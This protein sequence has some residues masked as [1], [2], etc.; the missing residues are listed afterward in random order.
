VGE[1]KKKE[2][3]RTITWLVLF[4]QVWVGLSVVGDFSCFIG[5]WLLVVGCRLLVVGCWLLV[6]GCC[7]FVV[8]CRDKHLTVTN[9]KKRRPTVK[10]KERIS[11][12]HTIS[13]RTKNHK[14][15]QQL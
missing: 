7:L 10:N 11:K 9:K 13:Q 2:K 6:D 15:L 4:C 14:P 1:K 3:K 8:G 5:Y 12:K